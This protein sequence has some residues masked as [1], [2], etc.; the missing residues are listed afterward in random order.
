KRLFGSA[1]VLLGVVSVSFLLLH[2]T[3][4]DPVDFIL[5]E[6]APAANRQAL[7]HELGLDQTLTA[8]YLSFLGNLARGDLG[9]GYLSRKAVSQDLKEHLPWTILLGFSSMAL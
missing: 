6:N 4:G 8:Q 3:P 2:L 7:R 1:I 9:R 5:G